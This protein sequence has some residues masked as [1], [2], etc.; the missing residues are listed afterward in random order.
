[1]IPTHLQ[2]R[3]LSGEPKTRIHSEQ[4]GRWLAD[5]NFIKKILLGLN[6][7]RISQGSLFPGSKMERAASL[8]MKRNGYDN[9]ERC[10]EGV[11]CGIDM[12]HYYAWEKGKRLRPK[13][14]ECFNLWYLRPCTDNKY[15]ESADGYQMLNIVSDACAKAVKI[16]ACEIIHSPFSPMCPTAYLSVTRQRLNEFSIKYFYTGNWHLW[17]KFVRKFLFLFSKENW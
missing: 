12:P 15:Q 14:K 5:A 6:T 2:Q 4:N 7:N 3:L 13:C 17:L 11:I 1:M 16:Y 10:G 8:I 9:I